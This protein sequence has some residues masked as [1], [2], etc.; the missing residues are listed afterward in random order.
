MADC[1]LG[2]WCS[3]RTEVSYVPTWMKKRKGEEEAVSL[4]LLEKPG[5]WECPSC[6]FSNLESRTDC[7]RNC[8]PRSFVIYSFSTNA[9]HSG[10]QNQ[11][12]RSN[13][14]KPMQN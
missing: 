7:V 10:Q 1:V 3:Q 13:G 2:Y 6:S 8:C 5:E 4:E 11:L 9:I 12:K 14:T